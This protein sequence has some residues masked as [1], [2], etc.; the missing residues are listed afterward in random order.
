MSVILLGLALLMAGILIPAGIV[1]G[2]VLGFRLLLWWLDCAQ[3]ADDDDTRSNS[4]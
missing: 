4:N 1:I 2:L 3:D